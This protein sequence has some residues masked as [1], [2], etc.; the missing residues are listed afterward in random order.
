MRVHERLRTPGAPR[1]RPHDLQDENWIARFAEQ[2]ERE[3]RRARWRERIVNTACIALVVL[4][5]LVLTGCE[6]LEK[7][8]EYRLNNPGAHHHHQ[9]YQPF[10]S[11]TRPDGSTSGFMNHGNG[12]VHQ[13]W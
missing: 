4:F 13:V 11:V 1:I 5:A 7:R 8:I 2:C 3:D 10:T 6:T 9:T 12:V